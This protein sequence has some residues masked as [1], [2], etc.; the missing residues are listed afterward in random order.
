MKKTIFLLL[1]VTMLACGTTPEEQ[2]TLHG[3]IEEPTGGFAY[4]QDRV[5]GQMIVKDSISI[6]DG[7]F[8]FEGTM[9]SPQMY[10]I[11]IDG[12]SG[13]IAIFMEN[14]DITLNITQNEPL[15]YTVEGSKS[16]DI[17][18]E[19]NDLVAPYDE[20]ARYVQKELP[21][22]EKADK[23]QEVEELREMSRE[24]AEQKKEAVISFIR[25]YPDM[26]VSVYIAQRQLMHGASAEELEEIF[27][28]FD[29]SLKGTRYYDEME[30]SLNTL[31]RVAIGKPAIDFTLT[32]PEG[33]A[34]SLSDFRGEMVLISFWASWCPYCRDA[35]PELVR[36]YDE[37]S[38]K[39]FEIVGVSLDRTREAWVQGIEEDELEWPQVSDLQG[40]RSGPAADYAVR[41]IPQNVLIDQNGIIIDRNLDYYELEEKLP[42]LLAG[43]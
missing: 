14:S 20:R 30:N 36:I 43:V 16:H 22:A 31:R 34:V 33:E 27:V 13:R 35:N 10:Y 24:V 21:E 5:S 3:K 12:I 19:M 9:D 6:K 8:T 38:D 4:L 26:A 41:S 40:W 11:S 23:K 28:L 37:F 29:E 25:Q 15:L 17:Y 7:E 1:T 32:N 2:Y 18:Q 39:G 42:A